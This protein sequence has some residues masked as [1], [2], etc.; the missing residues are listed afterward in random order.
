MP[1]L[2]RNRGQ[3]HTGRDGRNLHV[4]RVGTNPHGLPHALDGTEEPHHFGLK[5][6]RDDRRI[7]RGQEVAVFEAATV[8]AAGAEPAHVAAPLVA[9]AGGVLDRGA[10]RELRGRGL[11]LAGVESLAEVGVALPNVELVELL[12]D[13]LVRVTLGGSERAFLVHDGAEL[14]LELLPGFAELVAHCSDPFAAGYAPSRQIESS[15]SSA[16]RT[17][18][19]A[20]FVLLFHSSPP[21]RR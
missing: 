12:L 1:A 3:R 16:A 21:S 13:P 5:I 9:L 6:G 18:R 10:G 17:V 11:G 20:G 19:T 4:G 2:G 15:T 7:A 8:L 14:S